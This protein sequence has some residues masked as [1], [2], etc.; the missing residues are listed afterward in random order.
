MHQVGRLF[1]A[2]HGAPNEIVGADHV[3][4]G[5]IHDVGDRVVQAIDL[6]LQRG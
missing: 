2:V 5:T 4:T 3:Q 1:D 6:R